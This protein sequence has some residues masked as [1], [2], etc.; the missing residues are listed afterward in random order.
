MIH[1]WNQNTTNNTK[2]S[3]IHG[4]VD[5]SIDERGNRGKLTPL[6]FFFKFS[7]EPHEIF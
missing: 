1:H 2:I 3:F 4:H 7:L 5:P 6:V